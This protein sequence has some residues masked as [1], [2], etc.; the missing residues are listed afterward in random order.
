MMLPSRGMTMVKGTIN[1]FP[2]QT[3]L[4]PDGCGSH[5]F[6]LDKHILKALKANSGLPAQAGNTVSVVIEHIKEWPDP[7]IPTDLKKALS[8]TPKVHALWKDITPMARWDWIRWIRATKNP[9]TRAK[10]IKVACSKLSK[11]TRRPCCFNRTMCTVPEVSKNGV[12]LAP[13]QALK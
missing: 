12:L 13:N 10:R 6:K 3:A 4:E 2:F 5:W 11:G 7:Q 9:E 8:F 1:S